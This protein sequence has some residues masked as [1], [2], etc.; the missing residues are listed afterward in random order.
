MLLLSLNTNIMKSASG[1]FEGPAL[2]VTSLRLPHVVLT[3]PSYF[4]YLAGVFSSFRIS[5]TQHVVGYRVWVT[6]FTLGSRS[7]GHHYLHKNR[8]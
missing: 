4:P 2:I 1:S 3:S 5:S 8:R 7:D 6:V